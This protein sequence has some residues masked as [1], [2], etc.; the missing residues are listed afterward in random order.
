V[1]LFDPEMGA[2]R[3]LD[4]SSSIYSGLAW[5][6]DS[7][8]LAVLRSKTDDRHDGSTQAAIAW[9]HLI[10]SSE[11]RHDYD[12]TSDKAFPARLRVFSFRKASWSDDGGTVFL[13]VAKWNEKPPAAKTSAP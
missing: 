3:V 7:A 6:K 5:R 9:T 13:G 4:S 1:Q 12:P 8:D 2:L 10:D 11:A